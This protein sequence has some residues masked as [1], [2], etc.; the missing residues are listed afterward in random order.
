[1]LELGDAQL[2]L[3]EVV[4]RHEL[5]VVDERMQRAECLF[6][7]LCTASAHA[8]RELEDQL[9][10]RIDDPLA[11]ARDH[12]ASSAGAGAASRAAPVRTAR[13]APR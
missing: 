11:T 4:T 3:V 6:R 8:R 12:A 10:E 9:L 13:T 7:E 2:E 5:Q 1:M